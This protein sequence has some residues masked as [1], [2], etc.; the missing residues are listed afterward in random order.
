MDDVFLRIVSEEIAEV[1]EVMRVGNGCDNRL[2]LGASMPP[3]SRRQ[4]VEEALGAIVEESNDW[5]SCD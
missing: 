5:L 2:F 1:D 4:S 3:F